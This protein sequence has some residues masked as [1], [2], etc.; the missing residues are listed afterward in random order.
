[1]RRIAPAL[2]CLALAACAPATGDASPADTE[3]ADAT[4]SPTAPATA[5]EAPASPSPSA[6]PAPPAERE[7]A[8]SPSFSITI[9]PD[10]ENETDVPDE[11]V[12]LR[13]T[14]DRWLVFY[15][16]GPDTVEAWRELVTSDERFVA[17]EPEPTEVGG[18]TGVVF[19]FQLAEGQPEA[20]LFGNPL[21][22]WLV[23]PDRPNR[24]WIVDVDGTP[25]MVV[26]DAPERPF[27]SWVAT[28]EE[29]L[30]TLTWGE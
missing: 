20:D 8:W 14:S 22:G 13:A 30:A 12:S 19:D 25:V 7:I 24:A 4:A 6:T 9:P 11:F 1:M 15:N 23:T 17:T 3:N 27:E 10:W 21:Y 29:A 2:L 5:S 18:A 26:T 16:R 28:V